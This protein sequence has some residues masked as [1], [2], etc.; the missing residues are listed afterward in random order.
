M[1][2][3]FFELK[4]LDKSTF[5]IIKNGL[6]FCSFVTLISISILLTYIF[7]GFSFLYYLGIT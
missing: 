5:K 3:M 6:L 1:Q 7:M 2:K 4:N